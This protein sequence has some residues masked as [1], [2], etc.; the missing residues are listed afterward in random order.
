MVYRPFKPHEPIAVEPAFDRLIESVGGARVSSIVGSSPAFANADYVFSDAKIVVELKELTTDWPRLEDYQKRISDLWLRCE[1]AGRLNVRHASGEQPVPRD[2]RR[3]FLHLL[4]KPIKRVLEKANRQI[5]ETHASL[6]HQSGLG[7]VLLVIDGLL[8]VAPRFLMA[9]VSKILAHDYCSISGVVLITVNEYVDV[10]GDDYARL[11][12]WPNYQESIP[13]LLVDFVD[14]LG[15]AWFNQLEKDIGG[16]DV[17]DE[18]PDRSW[19][20]GA[21][22]VRRS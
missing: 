12:W 2:V 21:H 22:F 6:K 14:D 10:P 15:R 4:R 20:E 18:G 19:T 7:V 9:L 17:R 11:I 8:T 13:E 16:F 3:E 1:L 5:K